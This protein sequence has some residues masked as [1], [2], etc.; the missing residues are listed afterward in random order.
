MN[1][2]AF[3]NREKNDSSAHIAKRRLQVAVGKASIDIDS[4][5]S[6]LEKAIHNSLAKYDIQGDDV[7]F[8]QSKN[9]LKIEIAVES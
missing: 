7:F 1:I 3:F 4:I 9:K 8:K 6:D 2:L 5:I